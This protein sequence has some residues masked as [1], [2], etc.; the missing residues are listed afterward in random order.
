VRFE[1]VIRAGRAERHFYCGV[2]THAW[3]TVDDD[4][5]P[6]IGRERND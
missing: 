1:R 2:C 4:V 3:V 5:E 6:E